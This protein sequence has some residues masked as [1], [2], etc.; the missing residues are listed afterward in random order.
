MAF[1]E[2]TEMISPIKSL[3]N[4]LQAMDLVDKCTH[5]T[6]TYTND[7]KALVVCEMKHMFKN[8]VWRD[9]NTRAMFLKH[10]RSNPSI[11]LST[12][13][14]YK[15]LM[16]EYDESVIERHLIL[17]HFMDYVHMIMKYCSPTNNMFCVYD[18]QKNAL[19]NLLMQCSEK[20]HAEV[21]RILQQ[22]SSDKN[23]TIQ[24]K[25]RYPYLQST[26]VDLLR[27]IEKLAKD[28]IEEGM[29]KYRY[30]I[31]AIQK[32]RVLTDRI[33]KELMEKTWHPSRVKDWCLDIGEIQDIFH[34]RNEI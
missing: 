13:G 28:I 5:P 14:M 27:N 29:S 17:Y 15:A 18:N 6:Y 19:F 4:L 23:T 9:A 20:N 1:D 26:Y 34:S 2:Y 31:Y 7:P 3:E 8:G 12:L 16:K 33:Q 10:H 25:C 11:Q 22:N 30:E 24:N 21:R 32:T